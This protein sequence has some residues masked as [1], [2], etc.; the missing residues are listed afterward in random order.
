M[1]HLTRPKW[2]LGPEQ[3]FLEKAIKII[4]MYPLATFSVKK[5]KTILRVGPEL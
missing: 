1:A 3:D 5:L 4:F 2:F